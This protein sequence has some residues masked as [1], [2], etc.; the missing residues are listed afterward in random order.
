MK[1]LLVTVFC[2]IL[3]LSL[4]GCSSKAEEGAAPDNSQK[5]TLGPNAIGANGLPLLPDEAAEGACFS[6]FHF[7]LDFRDPATYEYSEDPAVNGNI[8]KALALQELWNEIKWMDEKFGTT[9]A[10]FALDMG[11]FA[12]QPKNGMASDGFESETWC[13]YRA[14]R[15]NDGSP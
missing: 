15:V 3:S 8:S 10:K 1:R 9:F 14:M 7:F 2:L 6:T 4:S 5:S 11:K 13:G 12:A